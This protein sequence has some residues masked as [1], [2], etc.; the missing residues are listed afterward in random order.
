MFVVTTFFQWF[1]VTIGVWVLIWRTYLSWE[2][3]GI[4]TAVGLAVQLLLELP[5]G[6]FADMFGRKNTVLFGRALGVIG[7][8][9]LLS[10]KTFPY[11]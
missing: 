5:S 2:Q 4:I 9:F 3:I 10:L 7:F 6:A 11:L 1:Y 8:L